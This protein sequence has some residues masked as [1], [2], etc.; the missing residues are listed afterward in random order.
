MVAPAPAKN[1]DLACTPGAGA[2]APRDSCVPSTYLKWPRETTLGR[3]MMP[4]LHE[5]LEL[6]RSMV[7]CSSSTRLSIDSRCIRGSPHETLLSHRCS[8]NCGKGLR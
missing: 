3:F 2:G 7:I 8:W 6:R 4:R 1:D 5:A